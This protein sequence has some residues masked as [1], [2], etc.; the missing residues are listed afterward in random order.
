[1][2]IDQIVEGYIIY[3]R[4]IRRYS[5]NTIKSYKSDLTDFIKYCSE[6]R[7]NDVSEINERFVK[8]YLMNLSERN[9]EKISIV[10]KLSSLRG[11]FSFAF[12]NSIFF[13][14]IFY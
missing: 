6:N 8:S 10:R 4:N 1:M 7:K 11:L 12:K 3:L 5:T 13:K 14:L 2:K 9:I